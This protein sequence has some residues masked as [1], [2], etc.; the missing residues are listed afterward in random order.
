MGGPLRLPSVSLASPLLGSCFT[1]QLLSFGAILLEFCHQILLS[2]DRGISPSQ[3]SEEVLE[4]DCRHFEPLCRQMETPRHLFKF[5]KLVLVVKVNFCTRPVLPFISVLDRGVG[6]HTPRATFFFIFTQFSGEIGQIY[7]FYTH[8]V[9]ATPLQNHL[10]ATAFTWFHTWKG[11]KRGP[12]QCL[13]LPCTQPEKM[14]TKTNW[15]NF[16]FLGNFLNFV[17]NNWKY[18]FLHRLT[19]SILKFRWNWKC[20]GNNTTSWHVFRQH[21]ISSWGIMIKKK[22]LHVK[23]TKRKTC[24]Q[25]R[26]GKFGESYFNWRVQKHRDKQGS[27]FTEIRPFRFSTPN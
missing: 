12:R 21:V 7:G 8:Q 2:S 23:T 26:P 14:V 13:Y 25:M 22:E 27:S 11:M 19:L 9:L 18:T 16:I 24:C 20:F 17:W 10:S 4:I 3:G 15:T 1:F 6:G 5:R